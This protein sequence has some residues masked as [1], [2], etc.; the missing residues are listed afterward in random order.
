MQKSVYADFTLLELH[1]LAIAGACQ[2]FEE[3][4]FSRATG[5]SKDMQSLKMPAENLIKA[6]P[7]KTFA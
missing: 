3:W 2:I 6:F 7:T 1:K 5:I 4:G